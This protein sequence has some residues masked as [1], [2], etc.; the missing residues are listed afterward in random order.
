MKHIALL[1]SLL[2]W[3]AAAAL[4][5]EAAAPAGPSPAEIKLREALRNTMLQ[6]KAAQD[7]SAALQGKLAQSE[8]DKTAAQEQITSLTGKLGELAK[9]GAAEKEAADKAQAALQAQVA[10]RDGQIQ[11]LNAALAKWKEGY[12]LAVAALAATEKAKALAVEERLVTQR[13]LEARE[14]QNL[15][16][17]KLADEIL[18]RYKKFS[19]GD[20]L[21]AKEP[22]TGITRSRLEGLV[23]EYREKLQEHKPKP[24]EDAPI[25]AATATATGVAAAP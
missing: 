9:K 21:A 22:F 20:A 17:Y 14:L 7:E 10:A 8:A 15:E 13:K 4:G 18:T 25:A 12:N 6:L 3:T 16:L 5:A 1:F 24:G 11:Q 2:C 19:L 23:Q